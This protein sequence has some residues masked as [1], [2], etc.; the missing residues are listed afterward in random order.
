MSGNS[1]C[2]ELANEIRR[3]FVISRRSDSVTMLKL[4]M[5]ACVVM[6]MN[7]QVAMLATYDH[8]KEV[9]LSQL[10]TFLERSIL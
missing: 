7:L 9:K 4:L 5:V 3:M 8:A 10:S 2:C 1:T 6:V